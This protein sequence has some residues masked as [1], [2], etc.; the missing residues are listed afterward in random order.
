MSDFERKADLVGASA[1]GRSQGAFANRAE[2][3][4]QMPGIAAG[5]GAVNAGGAGLV[6]E[7]ASGYRS[8]VGG[9]GGLALGA[10]LPLLGPLQQLFATFVDAGVST[11]AA[12]PSGP[13]PLS[14][15]EQKQVSAAVQSATEQLSSG[16]LNPVTDGEARS[17]L[18]TLSG[19]PTELQGQAVEKL[20]ADSFS[21]LL[22]EVPAAERVKF[23]SLMAATSDPERKL[24]LF[25]EYHKSKVRG[26]AAQD[27]Q[28]TEDEGGLF[29][30]NEQQ[31]RNQQTNQQRD[32]LVEHTEGEVDAELSFLL[33]KAK[34][35]KLA[36]E[37]VQKYIDA[38]EH[39]HDAE[40]KSN[41]RHEANLEGLSDE[42][43]VSYV[44]QR[45]EKKL[46][47]GLLNP[48]TD[49][50]ATDALHLIQGLPKELQ[51]RMLTGLDQGAFERLLDNVPDKKPEEFKALYE[52]VHDPERKLLLW[53]EYH[54]SQSQKDAK[55]HAEQGQDAATKRRNKLRS[56][57]ADETQDEVDDEVKQLQK[58]IRDGKATEHDIELLNERK[59][60]EH[61][62]EMQYNVNLTNDKGSDGGFL[63]LGRK[64]E[65]R[66]WSLDELK[67]LQTSFSRLPKDLITNNRALDEIHRQADDDG[68][69]GTG[70]YHSGTLIKMFDSGSGTTP[71]PQSIGWRFDG[72]TSKLGGHP[73]GREVTPFEAVLVH[74]LGHAVHDE[75]GPG[76]SLFERYQ[77]TAG[78]KKYSKS[79]LEDAMRAGLLAEGKKTEEIDAIV[80]AN[81]N[82]FEEERDKDKNYSDRNPITINGAVYEIDPYSGKFLSHNQGAI[83]DGQRWGYARSNPK[84]HF[85]EHFSM[86]VHNPE[87]LHQ[88]LISTPKQDLKTRQDEYE[89]KKAALERLE[90]AG[91]GDKDEA[92]ALRSDVAT[93]KR[94]AEEAQKDMEQREKQWL[95]MRNDILHTDAQQQ[96]DTL[97][98]RN[99]VATLPAEKQ[100]AAQ[101]VQKRFE[102]EVERCATP[103]QVSRL[104]Q[105]LEAE[106]AK[107]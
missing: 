40:R 6:S 103:E 93:A 35:G 14:D 70:G 62:L 104:R 76:G 87:Q 55:D 74:E 25:A 71:Q 69:T 78:W 50:E 107:L 5:A 24:R 75:E 44:T 9:L 54:K 59:Q 80:D 19:L 2:P 58:K 72:E 88:D 18:A 101:D 11:V 85:A 41:T 96:Q 32:A 38:K 20:D 46:E 43:R 7:P 90:K 92:K 30:Q 12:K 98:F 67:V 53:A 57:A 60:L 34:D 17:A 37:A 89:A 63:G 1:A 42:D 91:G 26:D 86:A 52:A 100:G 106:L 28:T 29:S 48:V 79:Q 4:S 77:E 27:R 56:E 22:S 94:E 15:A 97:A 82:Q 84:D 8:A 49:G 23:K 99:S 10:P 31:R 95:L 47:S 102:L 3:S 83:P 65:R 39:E 33:Q 21:A 61:S 45:V 73:S 36:P 68:D 64:R 81:L 66:E 13:A 16:F 105:A 51:G